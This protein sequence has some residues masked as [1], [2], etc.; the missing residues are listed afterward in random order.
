MSL[1]RI[2]RQLKLWPW[3]WLRGAGFPCSGVLELEAGRAVEALARVS[4]ADSD[5]SQRLEHLENATR[6]EIEKH[7]GKAR[8]PFAKLLKKLRKRTLSAYSEELADIA[9]EYHAADDA[10]SA[11]EGAQE[12]YR[13]AFE[14]DS[15]VVGE[16]LRRAAQHPRFREAVAWQN[17]HG[18]RSGIDK[19]ESKSAGKH[20]RLVANYLQRYSTKN[21]QIG[22]F[23]PIGWGRV[24]EGPGVVAPGESLL[25]KREVYFSYW[26]IA[27]LAEVLSEDFA[28][29]KHLRPRLVP[30]A[31]IESQTLRY[32]IDRET[33]VPQSI[34]YVLSR[35][36]GTRPAQVIADAACASDEVEFEDEDEVFEL[37]EQMEEKGILLWQLDIPPLVARPQEYLRTELLK[38]GPAAVA[39]LDALDH[40]EADRAALQAAAGDAEAVADAHLAVVAT[41]QAVTQAE[42][43]RNAG[44][45][46]GA[47]TPVYEDCV[48]D[49]ELALPADVFTSIGPALELLTTSAR[50]CSHDVASKYRAHFDTTYDALGAVPVSMSA[51]Y[52]AVADAMPT[53]FG[54]GGGMV[55][56]SVAELKRRWGAVLDIDE[57]SSEI[58]VQSDRIRDAVEEQ[59]AAPGPGWPGARFH[60]PDLLFASPEGPMAQDDDALVVLGEMHATT[61]SVFA[62]CGAEG[63]PDLANA[64]AAYEADSPV[65]IEAV[66]PKPLADRASGHSMSQRDLHLELGEALSMRP[67]SHVLR[68]RDLFV[69]RVDGNLVVHTLDD[70]H[71]FDVIAFYEYTFGHAIGSRFGI[72]GS[73]KHRPRVRID[74]LVVARESWTFDVTELPFA[75]LPRGPEQFASL[76]RWRLEHK[77]PRW[78]FAKASNERKPTFVDMHSPIIAEILCNQLRKSETVTFSEMLPSLDQA[79]LRDRDDNRYVSELRTVV[80]DDRPWHPPAAS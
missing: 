28:I 49:V 79:W 52:N 10:L 73:A 18:L 2:S 72:V 74:N 78:V 64:L 24:V 33:T 17:P 32:G 15:A 60:C 54:P 6:E 26:A 38:I 25:A 4:R 9:S 11:L 37:L 7:T 66:I 46:Y 34:A 67:R 19:L 27:A 1:V 36:D 65:H 53:M 59:F 30:T 62:K 70:Q 43:T 21:D 31:S 50:W 3:L 5:V 14:D 44:A 55:A 42:A 68:A 45:A 75:Q 40:L 80:V 29:K 35:A 20:Q 47:R 41:F 16:A 58:H 76:S 48:R 22:F 51:F 71:R 57:N 8:K 69:S 63:W 23:G 56:E 61:F 77:L 12:A 13:R 39:G